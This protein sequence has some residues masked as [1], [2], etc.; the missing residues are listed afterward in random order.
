MIE[1]NEAM[2]LIPYDARDFKLD[3]ELLFCVIHSCI[4]DDETIIFEYISGVKDD[5][6]LDESYN[7][8][9]S[10]EEF[11]RMVNLVTTHYNDLETRI[12]NYLIP[13]YKSLDAIDLRSALACGNFIQLECYDI[14]T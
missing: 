7:E 1:N 13:Q 6:S 8:K 10:V 14:N 9:A 3:S 5:I 4:W 2:I 11:D 12:K